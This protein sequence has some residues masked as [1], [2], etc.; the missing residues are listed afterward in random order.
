MSTDARADYP[1]PGLYVGLF[2]GGTLKLG[3]WDLGEAPRGD[4]EL[5][6]KSAPIVGLR[7]GYHIL[8]RLVGEVGGGYLPLKSTEGESNT[9][10][11]YDFDVYY[12]LLPG[13]ISP[14]LGVG[15][16]AYL[17][18]DGGD[19]GGDNDIQIHAG[20]GVR[21]L[22]TDHIALR[23]EVRDYWVDSYS[24]LGG[25]NLELTVGVDVYPFA[26]EEVVPPPPD[27][28]GD[29]ILDS[30]DACPDVAGLSTLQGCPDRDNDG[31]PD[32]L[33]RCP[34]EPGDPNLAGCPP[35]DQDGDGVLDKDDL[36]PTVPGEVAFQGCLDSDRDGIYDHEDRCP[37]HAGPKETQ[38]CPDTDGDGV[39]DIDDKCPEVAGLVEH[40]GCIPEAV[41]AFTGT[42]KGINFETGSARILPN[43][44]LVLDNAVKVLLEFQ[45]LRL[46][47]DGHTDNTGTAEINQKLST[48]RAESVKIYLVSKGVD[49]S[50]LQTAGY[51]D[52]KPVEDN[53]TPKGRAANRRIEFSILKK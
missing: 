30:E 39:V 20:L 11:K 22:V 52:T 43:S 12:H 50:R 26:K 7:L 21:G 32:H 28:D 4:R 9:G 23:A 19:L 49:E 45:S 2:G 16:G 48:D 3:D 15:T 37:Q 38:G 24:T 31:V 18:T 34:D 6:P 51:G 44:F 40:D 47:I 10:F 27:R 42:I 8:P 25:N 29:G 17:T 53:A 1:D 41:A 14:F 33:D 46:Q 5:Q 13:D 36:C 35:P